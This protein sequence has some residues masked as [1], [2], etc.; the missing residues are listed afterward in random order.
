MALSRLR[1]TDLDKQ[2]RSRSRSWISRRIGA[3]SA[4]YA[5]DVW[6]RRA[7][8]KNRFILDTASSA[9]SNCSTVSIIENDLHN[10]AMYHFAT[11][12]VNT[13]P[14]RQFFLADRLS[15]PENIGFE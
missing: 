9:S 4:A 5:S 8:S 15:S 3:E 1:V 12:L 2:G 14:R 6:V 7:V 11:E 13:Q 10:S